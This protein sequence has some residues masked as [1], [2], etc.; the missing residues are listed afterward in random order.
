MNEP[1]E[2]SFLPTPCATPGAANAPGGRVPPR[3]PLETARRIAEH[4]VGELAPLCVKIEIA[5]SIRRR[6]PFCGDVDL[7]CI[8][9]DYEA[10]RERVLKRCTIA[11]KSDGKTPIGDGEQMLVVDMP[12]GVQLD[13]WFAK[14][15][16]KDLFARRP[17]TWGSVLLCRTGSARHNIHLAQ[18][19]RQQ[20]YQWQTTLGLT[21]AGNWIAGE[22]E[23]DIFKALGL[24]F[25]KPEERER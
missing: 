7:V 8:P 2:N 23:E 18:L 11:M 3:M 17:S 20:G 14:P 15:E 10:L 21:C 1:P 22:T 5:G 16:R 19:A 24:E 9:R 12:N 6:R 4:V 25:I 13:I